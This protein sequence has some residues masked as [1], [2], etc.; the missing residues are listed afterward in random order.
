MPEMRMACARSDPG[1]PLDI[2]FR[3]LDLSCTGM[4]SVRVLVRFRFDEPSC[5]AALADCSAFA[6]LSSPANYLSAGRV[7][8]R[9]FN[10]LHNS[11]LPEFTILPAD[12]KVGVF[13]QGRKI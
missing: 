10:E 6:C 5:F 7:V 3:H 2:S 11:V 4:S 12:S 1:R 8:R 9:D 13:P